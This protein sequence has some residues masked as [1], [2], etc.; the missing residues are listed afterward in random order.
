MTNPAFVS[1]S[2]FEIGGM[3]VIWQAVNVF[4]LLSSIALFS[5]ACRVVW[6]AAL[7]QISLGI[8]KPKEYV[9]FNTQLG[10]YATGNWANSYFTVAMAVHTFNSLVMQPRLLTPIGT[11]VGP[12]INLQHLRSDPIYGVSNLSCG[13]RDMHPKAQFFYHLFPIFAASMLSAIL[14]SVIFL[15]LRGTLNIK[16]GVRLVLDPYERWSSGRVAENYHR[17]VAR[18][19]RIYIAL[20]VPY[21][22]TR[23]LSMSGF[24][25]LGVVNV[26]LLYNTFRVLGPALDS[27][28]QK[29]SSM[30]YDS[31][32][33]RYP[34]P[35]FRSP[36]IAS[37]GA[38]SSPRST[39]RPL[40]PVHHD[41]ERSASVQSY[42]SYPISSSVSIGR[43]ITPVNE[44][45]L[46]GSVT[47]PEVV[48]Q[49][50]SPAMARSLGLHSRQ[51]SDESV[52][53]PAAPR[54]TR[55][56]VLH[57]PSMEQMRIVQA[58]LPIHTPE[59]S[60]QRQAFAQTLG[61]RDSGSS[62]YSC[63]SA[64]DCD[65]TNWE[66]RS[67]GQNGRPMSSTLNTNLSPGSSGSSLRLL[68]SPMRHTRSFSIAPTLSPAPTGRQ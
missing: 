20:L 7:R 1:F 67:L 58:W 35:S 22:V 9:F 16:G 48:S 61:R 3:I 25:P 26:A 53:L 30:G 28:S 38:P 51:V 55:S 13:I 37:L 11:A 43:E 6:L 23:L 41:Q 17:F 24:M 47:L 32:E 57:D 10:Y 62:C 14:Y 54:R 4:A 15:V 18:I 29:E 52:G 27:P 60:V 39:M 19:A 8:S 65:P 50:L 34:I 59:R 56:P 46:Q 42:Y 66:S 12:F 45:T 36:T 21:S 2:S 33:K 44:L 31:S 49:K 63:D 5:V 64:S 68:G 40:L